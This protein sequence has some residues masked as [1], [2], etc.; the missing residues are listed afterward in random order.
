MEPKISVCVSTMACKRT[1]SSTAKQ[2][3]DHG[4]ARGARLEKR[5][6]LDALLGGKQLRAEHLHHALHGPGIVAQLDLGD[7]LAPLQHLL[8][9]AH[10]IDQ[11]NRQLALSAFV[12]VERKIGLGPHVRFEL[13][14]L[15]EQLRGALELLVLDEAMHQIGARIDLLLGARRAGRPAK[16]SST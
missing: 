12:V 16:A 7:L 9:D 4:R 5:G 13:L 8:E 2:R 6:Q 14:L 11:R 3:A 15:M 10:Q 1:S